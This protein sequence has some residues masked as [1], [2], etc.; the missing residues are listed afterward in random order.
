M[1][2]TQPLRVALDTANE[3]MNEANAKLQAATEEAETLKA[4]LD[5]L[6]DQFNT[7]EAERLSAIRQVLYSNGIIETNAVQ[8]ICLFSMNY[9]A[10]F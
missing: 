3:A 10:V 1:L 8:S 5:L 6:S 2:A 7:A 9:F 4:E